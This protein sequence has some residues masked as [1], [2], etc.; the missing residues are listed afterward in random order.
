MANLLDRELAITPLA[1]SAADA[2]GQVQLLY[3]ISENLWG[4]GA[5]F[6]GLWL[7]P[8][9]WCALRSGWMPRPL[10][11]VLIAGAVGYVLSAG[12]SFLAPDLG[13]LAMALTM[14]ASIGE[15]WMV[16]YLLWRGLRRPA[17]PSPN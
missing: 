17:V 13:G 4:V 1:A 7:V 12:V 10:G 2:A 14:P 15:F 9:G 6:F 5:I 16:G 8:M 11:W 3:L